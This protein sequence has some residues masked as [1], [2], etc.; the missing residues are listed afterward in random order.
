MSLFHYFKFLNRLKKSTNKIAL[1][2]ALCL[3]ILYLCF[4][5]Y[6][7]LQSRVALLNDYSNTTPAFY[8]KTMFTS[9]VFTD[10]LKQQGNVLCLLSFL[11]LFVA[12]FLMRP[13]V[14]VDLRQ[15][16]VEQK[17]KMLASAFWIGLLILWT[18][19][20][21]LYGNAL[22]PLC[23][24]EAF[25]IVNFAQ[26][27]L[28]HLLTYYPLPNNHIF[29]NLLNHFAGKI[30]GNY[31]LSGRVLSG[32][33]YVLLM[34]SNYLF[35]QKIIQNKF[36]SFLCC[37]LLA[38]QLMIWG[39]GSQARGYSLYYLLQWFSF[40][41]FYEYFFG[42]KEIRKHWL[43]VFIICNVLG[44]YAIP[45]FLYWLLFEVMA[46]LVVM[47]HFRQLYVD[48]WKAILLIILL[49]FLLYL[50]V[51]CYSGID[52]VLANKFVAGGGLD[53]IQVL[54]Q[55][56]KY[57]SKD[58]ADITFGF[59]AFHDFFAFSCFFIPLILLVF[60]KKKTNV[61][62]PF[63]L[64]G[65]LSWASVFIIVWAT[66]Q[67]PIFRAIGFQMQL[68]LLLFLLFTVAVVQQFVS[69][70]MG[71]Q[72]IFVALVLAASIKVF[73]ENRSLSNTVLYGQNTAAFMQDLS[74]DRI[75]IAPHQSVWL[76]DES[77]MFH[78]LLDKKISKGNFDCTFHNQDLI[79]LSEDDQPNPLIDLNQ[80]LVKQK[81]SWFTIYQR[82]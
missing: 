80:Y 7:L 39:F 45:S 42:K 19:G 26:Q 34:C 32:I 44:L 57:Y 79:V 1:C 61:L 54:Q 21:F 10:V 35:I 60:F 38:Q 25:S 68:S 6:Y 74:Q 52:A 20:L 4:P 51:F 64:F 2:I 76:S 28:T 77:F 24:D 73:A 71:Q 17:H 47:L 49:S 82:K 3:G 13:F 63:L 11:F 62:A 78:F 72:A 56:A 81:I 46:S 48:F 59:A 16:L 65:L 36:I 8:R 67:V 29:F 37:A 43:L 12:G 23:T 69:N 14:R 58:I 22:Q 27:P 30:S 9:T 15:I 53:R 75:E 40:V 70:K 5:L 50:P 33:F 18:S 31:L 55:L 66:K 41:C